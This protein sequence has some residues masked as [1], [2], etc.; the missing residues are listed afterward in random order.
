M[1][2]LDLK[3]VGGRTD[4]GVG[5]GGNPAPNIDFVLRLACCLCGRYADGVVFVMDME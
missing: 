2:G 4:D 5:A 3:G 1:G